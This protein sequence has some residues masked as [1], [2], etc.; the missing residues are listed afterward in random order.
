MDDLTLAARLHADGDV[1]KA[2]GQRISELGARFRPTSLGRAQSAYAARQ[3]RDY[4]QQEPGGPGDMPDMDARKNLKASIKQGQTAMRSQ[5]MDAKQAQRTARDMRRNPLLGQVDTQTGG[6][7]TE[8]AQLQAQ[9]EALVQQ[10]RAPAPAA[11]AAPAP[12]VPAA[13]AAPAPAQPGAG[14]A[15]GN[16]VPAGGGGAQQQGQQMEGMDMGGFLQA[17]RMFGDQNYRNQELQA[18][19]RAV[20]Q[21]NPAY[22][23]QVADATRRANKR[24]GLL[25]AATLGLS[26][27]VGR[28]MGR[29][30][31]R[32]LAM[33]SAERADLED[34][35][36]S[37]SAVRERDGTD[38]LRGLK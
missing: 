11:P 21:A 17:A 37:K 25:N 5:Y 16:V 15:G 33:K 1:E 7:V 35:L 23:A 20:R 10:N 18:K 19:Q 24:G 13:E 34:L 9:N 3:K 12:P 29:R 22:Q 32:N 14:P 2:L 31:L 26:G 28:A 36:L 38:R 8:P 6:A 4:L 27:A 30:D